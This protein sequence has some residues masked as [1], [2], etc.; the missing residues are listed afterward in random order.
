[1]ETGRRRRDDLRS[2]PRR[3]S[4]NRPFIHEESSRANT[5]RVAKSLAHSGQGLNGQRI[6]APDRALEPGDVL[7]GDRRYRDLGKT[8][9]DSVRKQARAGAADLTN[10][11]GNGATISRPRIEAR[12]RLLAADPA[13]ARIGAKS[14]HFV[15]R[16]GRPAIGAS[17]R[18][19]E[20]PE[21]RQN[22]GSKRKRVGERVR[23]GASR[24][25]RLAAGSRTRG[26]A[27]RLAQAG[28]G[29]RCGLR[30]L[31]VAERRTDRG[32]C[33][34]SSNRNPRFC[35]PTFATKRIVGT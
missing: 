21:V 11:A 28:R 1:M 34:L 30:N 33:E 19:A 4:A 7:I 29:S 32:S 26:A 6:G 13:P 25:S 9:I 8:M 3:W 24:E 31:M 14:R 20:G 17:A 22:Q 16:P 12:N 5:S 10:G 27:S 18:L 2:G 35:P 23:R 15:V